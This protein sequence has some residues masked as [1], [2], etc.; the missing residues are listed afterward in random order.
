[1]VHGWLLLNF[2]LVLLPLIRGSIECHYS[3][4]VRDFV[5]VLRSIEGYGCWLL[6]NVFVVLL[7]LILRSIENGTVYF[8]Y[9]CWFCDRL[10]VIV[11]EFFRGVAVD[12][13]L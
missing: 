2:Y 10:M 13:V 8:Y 4:V 5:L 1:V 11:V 6:M 12:F 9:F 7:A 3:V